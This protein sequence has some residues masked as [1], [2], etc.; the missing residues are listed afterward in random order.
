MITVKPDPS[1]PHGGYAELSVPEK[2]VPG[3][4]TE[5][6][7]YDNYSE[8]YLGAA[9][10]QPTKVL[11]GPYKVQRDGGMARLVIGPEIV[12]QIEEYANVRLNV[13]SAQADIAWPDDVVPA[14]GAARIGGILSATMTPAPPAKPVSQAAEPEPPAA[15]P[16]A[17]V[18]PE[19]LETPELVTASRSHRGALSLGLLLLIAAI[20]AALWY[21]TQEQA[22]TASDAPEEDDPCASAT[23]QVLS[24]FNDQ[25][26]ALRTCG[27]AA[28]ADTALRLV[29]QGAEA[30]D[31]AALLLFGTVYDAMVTA[32]V[33]EDE[34]GFTFADTPATAADYYARAKAAGSEAAKTQLEALCARMADMTDTLSVGARADHCGE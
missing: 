15:A 34:I 33:I 28:T 8:R 27:D 32:P 29:E 19:K 13:G 4:T 31:P 3:D 14:P 10:W 2:S 5:V 23:L 20:G 24:S 11:F 7:V 21:F 1:H 22:V 25:V 30:G 26:D 16:K 12:N 17:P 6:A 18:A 9:G